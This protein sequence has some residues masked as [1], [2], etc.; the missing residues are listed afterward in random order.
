MGFTL[1]GS[2]P[3]QCVKSYFFVCNQL[4]DPQLTLIKS[5]TV[6][7][8]YAQ[9]SSAEILRGFVEHLEADVD[10]HESQDGT[11]HDCTCD[12]IT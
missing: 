12:V 1:A 7:L 3:A 6:T 5:F 8:I 11:Q 2:N 10:A 4:Y 9:D